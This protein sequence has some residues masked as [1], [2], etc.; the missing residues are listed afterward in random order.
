METGAGEEGTEQMT[1]PHTIK[2]TLSTERTTDTCPACG[3]TE[4]D[5]RKSEAFPHLHPITCD[6]EWHCVEMEYELPARWEICNRCKGDGTHVNPNID[7]HGITAEEWENEWGEEEQEM[8]MSGGY[9]VSCQGQ[10]GLQCHHGKV[11]VVD[12]EQCTHEPRKSL[13]ERYQAQ[14]ES[15]A[16]DRAADRRTRYMES[17]G[18]EGSR[19]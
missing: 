14:E 12:E 6:N 7:G 17:G 11:L 13:L 18:H 2:F 15:A 10:D 8:Y 19:W 5:E 9:D 1:R 4:E 16:H 3:A